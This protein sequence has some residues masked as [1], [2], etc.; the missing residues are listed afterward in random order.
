M[1]NSVKYW[2]RWIKWYVITIWYYLHGLAKVRLPDDLEDPDTN[3]VEVIWT[4]P[5]GKGLFRIENVPFGGPV[6]LHDIVRCQDFPN[7]FPLV[8]EL[9]SKSG[10][11]ALRVEFERDTTAEQAVDVIMELKERRVFYERSGRRV[12]MFNVE[13]SGDLQVIRAY[14][15]SKE[16]DGML[17]LLD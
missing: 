12:Y 4:K 5:L 11:H 14:L 17:R 3:N 10:N 16:D 8:I 2:F 6:D 1:L 7:D 9:V 15:Q 13:P